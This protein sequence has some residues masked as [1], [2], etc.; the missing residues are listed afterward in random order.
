MGT[1]KKKWKESWFKKYFSHVNKTAFWICLLISLALIVTAF[2]IPPQGVIDGSVIAATGELFAFAA[3][4]TV[5]DGIE[6]GRS[7]SISKGDTTMTLNDDD[8]IDEGDA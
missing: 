1:T 7:V 3:L 8:G 5:I 4:G 6:K 2:F